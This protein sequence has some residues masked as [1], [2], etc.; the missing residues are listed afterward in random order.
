VVIRYIPSED[1]RQ[2]EDEALI[3]R[4][5]QQSIGEPIH[6]LIEHVD[7]IPRTRAGKF[8]MIINRIGEN[9]P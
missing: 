1:F 5:F 7:E 2:D 3:L 4:T 9:P 8:K 6:W